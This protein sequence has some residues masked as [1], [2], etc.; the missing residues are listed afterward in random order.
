MISAFFGDN[1]MTYF[2]GKALLEG[3]RSQVAMM[4]IVHLCFVRITPIGV[5][6]RCF[7]IERRKRKWHFH[8]NPTSIPITTLSRTRP[9]LADTPS[10]AETTIGSAIMVAAVFTPPRRTSTVRIAGLAKPLGTATTNP[11][12]QVMRSPAPAGVFILS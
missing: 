12:P 7:Q 1:C 5:P 6:P 3:V 4:T 2:I 8:Y 11:L 10:L 9:V